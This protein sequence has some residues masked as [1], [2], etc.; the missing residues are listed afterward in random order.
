MQEIPSSEELARRFAS[1]SIDQARPL[2]CPCCGCKTLGKRSMFEICPICFWEDDGHDH[3][4]SEEFSGCNGLSL[5]EARA[6][7]LKYGACKNNHVDKVRPPHAVELPVS[8]DIVLA[9]QHSV[10]HREEVLVS[11]QCGCFYCCA[12]FRPSEI[13]DWSD[14][15]ADGGQT[16]LC[17]RCWMSTVIG[18]K[19]GYPLTT[20][21]L[22]AM[23]T[24]WFE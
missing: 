6:N 10:S 19:S 24:H 20:E 7:Y 15:I 3:H 12:I 17:P 22:A 16:A 1:F 9:H 21:F 5:N 18:S 23:R 4:N 14:D 8:S 2:R 11:E 13:T